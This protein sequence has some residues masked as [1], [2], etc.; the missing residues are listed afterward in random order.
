[1]CDPQRSLYD[2]LGNA[3]LGAFKV[4]TLIY[5]PYTGTATAIGLKALSTVGFYGAEKK[6]ESTL[7]YY[8]IGQKAEEV[9]RAYETYQSLKN[10]LQTL[11]GQSAQIG[12]PSQLIYQIAH[13]GQ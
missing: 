10:G 9:K 7:A 4:S 8:G 13:F 5:A 12:M 3:L 6:V 2:R 11:Q 1:M